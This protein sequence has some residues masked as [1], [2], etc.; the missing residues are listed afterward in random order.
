MKTKYPRAVAL[1]RSLPKENIIMWLS[2]YETCRR[3][4]ETLE[5]T[6]SQPRKIDVRFDL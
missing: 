4:M 1:L 6:L 5:R 2:E 3:M